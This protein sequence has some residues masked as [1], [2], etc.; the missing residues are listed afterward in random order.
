MA[1]TNCK[2]KR[3]GES[4]PWPVTYNRR[5]LPLPTSLWSPREGGEAPLG[6]AQGIK[7]EACSHNPPPPLNSLAPSLNN[8]HYATRRLHPTHPLAHSSALAQR[9]FPP[10]LAVSAKNINE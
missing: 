10:L 1:A 5:V 8:N 2:R 9:K 6:H 7:G 3:E 4:S